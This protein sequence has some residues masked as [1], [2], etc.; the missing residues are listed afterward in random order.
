M[1]KNLFKYTIIGFIFVSILGSLAHFFYEWSGYNFIVGLFSAVNESVW[2]HLKLLFFP[3]LIWSIIEFFALDKNKSVFPA[4]ALGAVS[5]M[6][7]IVVFFYVYTGITGENIDFLNIISFFIGVAVSFAVD[8]MLI[9]KEKFSTTS[10]MVI[11]ITALLII[12][13]FFVLFTVFPVKIPLFEDPISS[14]YGI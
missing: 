12:M 14:T 1:N 7:V 13:M 8:Y 2:E 10:G 11:G 5:G 9:K 4:K 3:Y 6:T